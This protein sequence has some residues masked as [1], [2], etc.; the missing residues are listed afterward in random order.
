MTGLDSVD[1]PLADAMAL[2]WNLESLEFTTT[3]TKAG[4][5]INW[6][7]TLGPTESL[8]FT[9]NNTDI[10]AGSYYR[11]GYPAT[12]PYK[13]VCAT[14][15]LGQSVYR[16]ANR[17]SGGVSSWFV[18]IIYTGKSTTAGYIKIAY[19]FTFFQGTVPSTDQIIIRNP[20]SQTLYGTISG[21]P[22]SSGTFYILGIPFNWEGGG[23]NDAG[24]SWRTE[25]ATLSCT[26][27]AFTY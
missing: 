23:V 27:S 11:A 14:L 24:P 9:P 3:G 1:V 22:P 6:T 21:T 12:E 4:V 8:P 18:L 19:T 20:N 15:S 17:V 13:R 16:L 26:S 5:N 7:A 25:T 2:F 10:S